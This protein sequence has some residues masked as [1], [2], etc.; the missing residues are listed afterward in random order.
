MVFCF[1]IR[2][3]CASHSV[4]PSRYEEAEETSKE[5]KA[6]LFRSEMRLVI[7]YGCRA[8]GRTSEKNISDVDLLQRGRERVLENSGVGWCD[9][10][11]GQ[12]KPR[13]NSNY[14]V[15]RVISLESRTK[16]SRNERNKG[17]REK[18]NEKERNKER[19]E[20]WGTLGFASAI[21]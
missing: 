21:I 13:G 11:Y 3:K 5:T 10:L 4:T 12:C 19:T 20:G 15:G 7:F 14:G 17:R 2:K 16:H 6:E 9:L 1:E 8:S 18:R